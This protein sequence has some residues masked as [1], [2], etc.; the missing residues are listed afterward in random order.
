MIN[1]G[2]IKAEFGKL[3]GFTNPS[4]PDYAIVDE[5]N[6]ESTS[7]LMVGQ[8]GSI[9]SVK[10]IKDLQDNM[11][12]TD[13]EFNLAL[14]EL[15]EN[16]AVTVCNRILRGKTDL[17][18]STILYPYEKTFDVLEH[19][20]LG[21]FNGFEIKQSN[22]TIAGKISWV[23]LSFD[24]EATFN[25]YLFNSNKPVNPIYTKEVTTTAGESVIIPLDWV[26]AD[27]PSYR[28]GIFYLGYSTDDIGEAKPYKKEFDDA[29]FSLNVPYFIIDSVR[30]NKTTKLDV[31]SRECVS[32]THG[33]NL[34]VE[35]YTDY[36]DLLVKN[37]GMFPEAIKLQIEAFVL[38]LILTSFRSNDTAVISGTMINSANIQ[39]YGS[40][41]L[42]ISGIVEKLDKEIENIAKTL[43]WT[44]S[45]RR[46][47]MSI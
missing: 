1:S 10:V 42:G 17:I 25:L 2:I 30:L 15:R 32:E 44:P 9:A 27:N 21:K 8:I 23:E 38:N 34:G 41:E 16:S 14:K 29:N 43:F 35:V 26:I 24:K 12:I 39:Y 36:T 7:G 31:R 40:K 11:D 13:E 22:S 20:T 4:S 45:I 6:Q 46:A 33:V 47:T 3:V 5:D 37:K 18:K 28:G 19:V